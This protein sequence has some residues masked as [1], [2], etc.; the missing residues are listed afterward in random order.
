VSR[1]DADIRDAKALVKQLQDKRAQEIALE[2]LQRERAR[3][4]KPAPK[5]PPAPPPSSGSID[6][7]ISEQFAPLGQTTVAQA[8][9]VADH[10]SSD[11]PNAVNAYGGG[12]GVFQYLPSVWPALSSS[13]GYGGRSAFD[14]GVNIGT[15]EWD[16]ANFGWADWQSDA[17][18]CN[19]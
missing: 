1:L 9:C 7:M 13:A 2:K 3:Q 17:A 14:T 8:L 18:A 19:L 15:A 6:S 16:V 11:N 10:E 5:P 4:P 12:A